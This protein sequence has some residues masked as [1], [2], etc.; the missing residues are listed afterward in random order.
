MLLTEYY[1][2]NGIMG[3]V[4]C[5]EGGA[6]GQGTNVQCFGGESDAGR[7]KQNTGFDGRSVFE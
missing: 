4:M 5:G 3:D 1:W 7:P 6:C 2:G